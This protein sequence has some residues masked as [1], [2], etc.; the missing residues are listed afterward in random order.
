M[1]GSGSGGGSGATRLS[2]YACAHVSSITELKS[3]SSRP[4]HLPLHTEESLEKVHPV[5][6]VT[7]QSLAASL[8][9]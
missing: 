8:V 6:N 7:N 9:K 3:Y 5:T 4:Q 1:G 2:T